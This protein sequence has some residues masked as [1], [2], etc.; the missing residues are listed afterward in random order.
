MAVRR[1][2]VILLWLCAISASVQAAPIADQ[3]SPCKDF[4]PIIC[5]IES[6]NNLLLDHKS[7]G[8]LPP[9]LI[10]PEQIRRAQL[11]TCCRDNN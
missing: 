1:C 2:V 10:T 7:P 9:P 8:P 5:T 11:K 3:S 6:V 4:D